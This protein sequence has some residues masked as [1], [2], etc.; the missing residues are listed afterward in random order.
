MESLQK[1]HVRNTTKRRRPH[2]HHHPALPIRRRNSHP[3]TQG[4][5]KRTPGVKFSVRSQTY[6]GGSSININWTDGPTEPRVQQTTQL[7]AGATFDGMTDMQSYHDSLLS[8]DDGAE[9]VHF[10]ADFVSCQRTLSD[11]F[12]AKLENEIAEFTGEPYNHS[13]AYHADALGNG[14]DEPAKLYVDRHCTTWGSDLLH[15]LAWNR[16][17][18][19]RR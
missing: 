9:V 16:P 12:R 15:R 11:D 7:F 14:I 3:R 18:P 13:T 2:A 19:A 17:M 10:A 4:A 5:Q 8:T 1:G 6:A